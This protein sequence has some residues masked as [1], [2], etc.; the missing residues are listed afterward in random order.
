MQFSFTAFVILWTWL[1]KTV[2][3]KYWWWKTH[4]IPFRSFPTLF[5]FLQNDQISSKGWDSVLTSLGVRCVLCVLRDGVPKRNPLNGFAQ[6][7]SC[8]GN[9]A[10]Y[11]CWYRLGNVLESW[12]E[13]K[14][15]SCK[16]QDVWF[17]FGDRGLNQVFSRVLTQGVFLLVKWGGH[18]V[19]TYA[20]AGAPSTLQ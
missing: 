19:H 16:T 3:S 10:F 13:S 12:N 9:F 18:V 11:C 5:S 20:S 6:I 8:A 1:C 4:W 14:W 17:V 2:Q 7:R 15:N